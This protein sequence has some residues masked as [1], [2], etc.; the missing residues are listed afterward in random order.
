M[1]H[2]PEIEIRIREKTQFGSIGFLYKNT[3]QKVSVPVKRPPI[4]LQ[5]Y[6]YY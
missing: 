4:A 2:F 5:P 3:L 1:H 6:L